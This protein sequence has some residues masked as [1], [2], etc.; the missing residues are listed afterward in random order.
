MKLLPTII[1]IQTL[2]CIQTL[3]AFAFST[4]K[5]IPVS[6]LSCAPSNAR[7]WVPC[8]PVK[9]PNFAVSRHSPNSKVSLSLTPE[10]M[11]EI[12]SSS[13]TTSAATI[14]PVEAFSQAMIG[15]ISG[16]AILLVPVLA[17][18]AVASVVAWG[19]VAYANPASEDMGEDDNF[20]GYD[21]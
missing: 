8:K 11:P 5:S 4:S 3:P 1:L 14:D 6:S 7:Q 2:F 9:R 12:F 16:P 18:V 15:L 20:N 10:V 13:V 21:S 17:A 19:I